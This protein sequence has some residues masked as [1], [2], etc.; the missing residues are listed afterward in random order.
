MI[1][2]TGRGT[3]LSHGG[4]RLYTEVDLE[5]DDLIELEFLVSEL[6]RVMAIV[7]NRGGDYFGLQFLANLAWAS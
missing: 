6:L 1:A 7:R 3:E 5:R 2:V 4:M